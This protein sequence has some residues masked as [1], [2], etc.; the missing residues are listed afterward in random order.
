MALAVDSL[1]KMVGSNLAECQ[2]QAFRSS[3]NQRLS[4]GAS[5]QS[6]ESQ[7]WLMLGRPLADLRRMPAFA[8]SE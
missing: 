8:A 2:L 5:H 7:L 6:L 1:E 3:S 4:G